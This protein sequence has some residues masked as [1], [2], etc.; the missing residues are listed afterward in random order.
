[1][2]LLIFVLP[3]FLI[4]CANN[5]TVLKSNF[6]EVKTKKTGVL[7]HAN[8]IASRN[9]KASKAA[10]PSITRVIA[11]PPVESLNDRPQELAGDRYDQNLEEIIAEKVSY[12]E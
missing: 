5:Q 8:K 2:K 10:S 7:L 12:S 1:M 11:A 4:S 6:H 3:L 9:P